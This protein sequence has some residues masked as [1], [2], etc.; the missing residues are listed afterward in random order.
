MFKLLYSAFESPLCD[1]AGLDTVF[2][3]T[4]SSPSMEDEE[5]SEVPVPEEVLFSEPALEEDFP[6]VLADEEPVD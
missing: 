1:D 6:D 3:M 5:L 2:P 4:M